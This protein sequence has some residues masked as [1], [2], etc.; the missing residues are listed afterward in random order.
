MVVLSVATY[1]SEYVDEEVPGWLTEFLEASPALAPQA[2][3]VQARIAKELLFAWGYHTVQAQ[4]SKV[5]VVG[6]MMKKLLFVKRTLPWWW[7]M[8]RDRKRLDPRAPKQS[9]LDSSY[10]KSRTK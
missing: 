1:F 4:V 3:K 5:D 8:V 7:L 9:P 10:K 2:L 6:S